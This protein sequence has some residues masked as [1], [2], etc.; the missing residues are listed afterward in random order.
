MMDFFRISNDEPAWLAEMENNRQRW[1][2]FVEKLEIRMDELCEAALPELRVALAEDE[3]V[4]KRGFGRM[5]SA[6]KGQLE[7]IREKAMTVS[8]ERVRSFFGQHA[9]SLPA[10][11]PYLK[12]LYEFRHACLE[13]ERSLEERLRQWVE[14]MEQATRRDFEAEY[15]AIRDEWHSVREAFSC[16]QCGAPIVIEKLFFVTTYVAC[17]HCRA[18]NTFEP[19]SS[20][21]Q[22]EFVARE[23][24]RSRTAHLLDACLA[25]KAKL[26][27]CRDNIHRNRA[28][29]SDAPDEAQ[30]KAAQRSFWQS[31]QQESRIRVLALYETYLDA[32]FAEWTSMV[33]DLAEHHLRLRQ[34]MLNDFK[35]S[36]D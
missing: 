19:G 21:R 17:S 34:S 2:A 28:S 35:S 5:F 8:E 22:L 10:G 16:H 32:L 26:V 33:P 36:G 31:Q 27:E 24:A 15:E 4:H 29:V 9:E 23:V 1:F 6:I 13:R 12:M 20:S 3:D 14:R 7:N 30:C 18:R 25:E 11:S